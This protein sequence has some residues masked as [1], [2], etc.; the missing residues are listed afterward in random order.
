MAKASLEE[1]LLDYE[2][3][4]RQNGLRQWNKDDSEAL[5]VRTKYRAYPAEWFAEGRPDDERLDP[6]DAAE[7]FLVGLVGRRKNPPLHP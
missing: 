6:Y 7:G 2:D 3:Y 5:A 4:L 1:L